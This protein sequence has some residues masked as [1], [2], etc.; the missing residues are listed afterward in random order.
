MDTLLHFLY[1]ED[2]PNDVE[3]VRETLASEKFPYTITH[4]DTRE[5]YITNLDT[6][7]YDLVIS[8]FTLPRFSGLEALKIL[9]QRDANLPFILISGTIGEQRAVEVLKNGA[10]DYLLKNHL[11]KLGSAIRRALAE[12]AERRQLHDATEQL[13]TSEAKLAEAQRIAHIGNWVWDIP[14][15][16]ITWSDEMFN[17]FKVP[18]HG[19]KFTCEEV[20]AFIH[21]ED[22]PCVESRINSALHDHTSLDTEYRI[23]LPDGSLRY[24]HALAKVI[25]GAGGT[26]HKLI[27]TAQDISERKAAENKILEL[28]SIIDRAK[29]AISVRTLDNRILF[30]N[31][32]AEKLY[33]WNQEEVLGIET[34]TILVKD[35]H[36]PESFNAIRIATEKGEWYGEMHHITKTGTGLIVQSHWTLVRDEQGRPKSFL[37]IST[38]IT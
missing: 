32:G 33:G 30:W 27:G 14:K 1:V 6:G 31:K 12:S 26:P 24:I 11:V 13:K 10:T 17:I 29:D 34:Q 35:E 20:Y 21:P 38:D 23:V 5:D 28:G 2:N 36:L 19:R 18:E 15:N 16:E 37:V 4:V 8:D 7:K 22:L 9:R 3:L 25:V